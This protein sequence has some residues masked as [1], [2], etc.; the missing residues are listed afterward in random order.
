MVLG[1]ERHV[2]GRIVRSRPVGRDI[3]AVEG[4]VAGVARPHPV[5]DIAAIF[6]DRI[7]R[8][9]DQPHVAHFEALDELVLVPAVEAGHEATIA[10]VLLAFGSDVL[11]ALLDRVVTRIGREALGPGAHPLGHVAFR[12]RHVDARARRGLQFGALGLGEEAVFEIIVLCGG[13]VLHRSA[14]AVMV[15]HHQPFG[16]NEA[17][18]TATERHDRAHREAGEVAQCLGRDFEARFA[19]IG[20]DFGQLVGRVHALFRGSGHGDGGSTGK[21]RGD[22]YVFTHDMDRFL[23]PTRFRG[24]SCRKG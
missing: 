2:V 14:R 19:Q 18:R 3:G 6:S 9:I 1:L 17:G 10:C 5:I 4:E 8:R 21:Q 20:G 13:I 15:R 12:D 16:R 24:A 23:S 22:G 7:G 11:H